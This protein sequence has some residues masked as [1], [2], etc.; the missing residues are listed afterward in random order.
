[1]K[2]W[3]WI[4]N[5]SWKLKW[6]SGDAL[7]TNYLRE[8]PAWNPVWSNRET[9]RKW[10]LGREKWKFSFLLDYIYYYRHLPP[11]FC[12]R[13]SCYGSPLKL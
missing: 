8:A 11:I 9:W 3:I 2:I 12:K 6:S 10:E 5:V 4:L 1:M 13:I 7:L